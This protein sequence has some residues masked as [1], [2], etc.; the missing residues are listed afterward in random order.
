[1]SHLHRAS[2]AAHLHRAS[3]AARLHRA[4]GAARLHRA[5]GAACL[6]RASGAAHLY[7]LRHIPDKFSDIVPNTGIKM[8]KIEWLKSRTSFDIAERLESTVSA[9]SVELDFCDSRSLPV[10]CAHPIVQYVSPS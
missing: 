4:N 5:S 3:G 2:G 9:F 8:R 1:M 6:H 10:R 7:R